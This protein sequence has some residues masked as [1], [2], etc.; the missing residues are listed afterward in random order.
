MA[1]IPA[2]I[3]MRVT[4]LGIGDR[5]GKKVCR[6]EC[7]IGLTLTYTR[8]SPVT[9]VVIFFLLLNPMDKRRANRILLRDEP[10]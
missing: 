8:G 7:Y 5:F 3:I 6:E 2:F 1:A 10:S 9:L 4:D